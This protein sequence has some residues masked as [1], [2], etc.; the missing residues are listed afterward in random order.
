MDHTRRVREKNPKY[1]F[2]R[3]RV[4]GITWLAYAGF[5]L[6]RKSFAVAKIGLEDDPNILMTKNQM[7]Y[8]DAGY[9]FAYAIGNFIWGMCGDRVGTRRVVLAGMLCSIITG[10]AMGVSNL[11]LL[12]GV[13]MFIQGLCQSTGWSPLAK[14][15]ANWFSQ[16]ERG[17]IMGWWSTNYAVGGAVAAPFA[18]IC[19][20]Y[21]APFFQRIAA[22][23]SGGIPA[24]L[25]QDWRFAFFGP[26][27]AL[28]VIWLAFLLLQKNRPSDVG[29]PSIEEYHGE[30]QAV[31]EQGGRP[32]DEVEGSW[33]LTVKVLRN[34]NV[35][36]LSLLYSLLKPTRYLILFWG[37]KYISETLG[38]GMAKSGALSVLFEI[39]GAVA[40]L[41]AGY[42]S[43]KLFQSRRMPYSVIC[44]FL[45][46]VIL[47]FFDPVVSSTH[48]AIALGFLLCA[49][50]FLLYGPEALISA[51]APL[52][53]GTKK[54]ASTASGTVNALGSLTSAVM[55]TFGAAWIEQRWGWN[56]LFIV[57]GCATLV[58]TLLLL[59]K[60]NSV[61]PTASGDANDSKQAT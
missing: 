24:F 15:I 61:P 34:R 57:L 56:V 8:V 51:T 17:V 30:P 54:G 9:M 33:E 10:F 16:R 48:S 28:V 52:D 43:D 58:A 7:G 36:F 22:S 41:V 60:W 31:L 2:W 59:P 40:I 32:E 18:G 50:G 53:F 3:W 29:L 44:L 25:V 26:A 46:A 11:V 12:F 14:N 6:T 42:A 23:S 37:P 21:F 39:T 5:Y 45:V 27:A 13:L 38:T 55:S 19:G 4:F 35:L 1:E 20:E 47:F 49:L